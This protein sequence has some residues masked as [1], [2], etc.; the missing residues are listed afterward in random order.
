MQV[1]E[2]KFI[3]FEGIDGSGKGT[4]IIKAASLIFSMNKNNDVFITREPT[5]DFGVIREVMREAAIVEKSSSNGFKQSLSENAEWYAEL[6]VKD[7][8]HHVKE[9]I[10]PALENGTHVL[11]DRYKYSTLAYQQT[12]GMSFDHLK[13]MHSEIS[14]I[15]NLTLIFDCDPSIAIERRKSSQQGATEIFDKAGL[16]WISKL[17]KNY[18]DLQSKLPKENIVIVDASQ[19]I[20]MVFSKVKH[21][22]QKIIKQ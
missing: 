4:Q 1:E 10:I 15:P 5:R 20:Q 8:K 21:E 16:E 7:R 18:L 14:L 12:Q 13:D 3:V 2:G 17:R 9:Y 22:I 11:C 6:F 19:S